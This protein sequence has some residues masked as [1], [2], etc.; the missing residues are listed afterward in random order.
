MV[1]CAVEVEAWVAVEVEEKAGAEVKIFE[2]WETRRK[3]SAT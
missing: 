3:R 2:G 1:A